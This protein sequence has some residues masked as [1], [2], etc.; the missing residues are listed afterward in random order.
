MA[1]FENVALKKPTERSDVAMTPMR[2]AG[3]PRPCRVYC[4]AKPASERMTSIVSFVDRPVW[5][6]VHDSLKE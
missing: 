3:P 4:A 6:S 1:L 5:S 2:S